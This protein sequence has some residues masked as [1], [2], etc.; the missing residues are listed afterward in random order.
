M[1]FEIMK[2]DAVSIEV[3]LDRIKRN[4]QTSYEWYPVK[5]KKGNLFEI[6]GRNYQGKYEFK[7]YIPR[8]K[9]GK[10]CIHPNGFTDSL[11][12]IDNQ[13]QIAFPSFYDTHNM[14]E[15]ELIKFLNNT[16]F[17]KHKLEFE[18]VELVEYSTIYQIKKSSWNK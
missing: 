12:S 14:N 1:H 15:D 13:G 11:Y 9:N 4:S 6:G 2:R 16:D 10:H 3:A 18:E 8:Y 5:N 17:K 7:A